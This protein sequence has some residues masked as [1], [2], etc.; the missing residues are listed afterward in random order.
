MHISSD[1]FKVCPEWPRLIFTPTCTPITEWIRGIGPGC[2]RA[3]RQPIKSWYSNSCNSKNVSFF[4]LS[5]GG[6]TMTVLAVRVSLFY[7]SIV[8]RCKQCHW[9]RRITCTILQ[10]TESQ[11]RAGVE[12][13][14]GNSPNV[15]RTRGFWPWGIQTWPVFVQKSFY[16]LSTTHS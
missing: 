14:M 12:N 13:W 6:Q 4:V 16:F 7:Q 15:D 2:T 3:R 9:N 5:L 11:G 10:S 1:N 8:V